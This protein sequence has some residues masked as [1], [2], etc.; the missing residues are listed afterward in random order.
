MASRRPALG[1]RKGV[2]RMDL[3]GLVLTLLFSYAAWKASAFALFGDSGSILGID[4]LDRNN[5]ADVAT[6]ACLSLLAISLHYWRFRAPVAVLV[7][8]VHL[9]L[10]SYCLMRLALPTTD[11]W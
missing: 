4:V 8:F 5:A 11:R 9:G 2:L 10:A 3:P 1:R 7:G 6:A